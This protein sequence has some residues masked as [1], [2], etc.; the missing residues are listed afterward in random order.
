MNTQENIRWK[1]LGSGRQT[2]PGSIHEQKIA[3]QIAA[4]KNQVAGKYQ[5]VAPHDITKLLSSGEMIVSPKIDG[6]TWFLHADNGE[7]RLLS[8]SGKIITD[9]PVTYEAAKILE[10]RHLLLTGELYA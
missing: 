10:K 4:Y 5:S 6:E 1:P 8:P 7:A 9:I 2:P 3:Q